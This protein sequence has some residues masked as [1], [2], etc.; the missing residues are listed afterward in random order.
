MDVP[1]NK[2]LPPALPQHTVPVAALGRA[3]GGLL[4]QRI[5]TINAPAGYGKSVVLAQL[6]QAAREQ[7]THTFWLSLDA[8]DIN[9]Q[10]LREWLSTLPSVA[11]KGKPLALFLDNCDHLFEGCAH[12]A[13]DELIQSSAPNVFFFLASRRALPLRLGKLRLAQQVGEA[14]MQELC[15]D[16]TAARSLLHEV[17]CR[18]L[19]DAQVQALHD[20]TEGWPAGLQLAALALR[21]GADPDTLVRELCQG[22][23][24]LTVYLDDVAL[25]ELPGELDAFLHCT[26][27]PSRFSLAWCREVLCVADPAS[28][29]KAIEQRGLPLI[30]LDR[31]GNWYRYLR[32]FGAT[33][34]KRMDT[35]APQEAKRLYRDSSIWFAASGASK[36]A[37]ECAFAAGDSQRA[38]T[39]L[40]H[41]ALDLAGRRGD[42]TRVMGWLSQLAPAMLERRPALRITRIAALLMTHRLAEADAE[43]AQ[44]EA[45][46]ALCLRPGRVPPRRVE[47]ILRATMLARCAWYGLTDQPARTVEA[48][49]RWMGMWGGVGAPYEVG[50]VLL[51]GGYNAC[52]MGDYVRAAADLAGA[53]R[54]MR[55]SDMPLGLAWTEVLTALVEFEAGSVAGADRMLLAA[56]ADIG[57]RFGTDCRGIALVAMMRASICYEQNRIEEAQA[58]LDSVGEFYDGR[59]FGEYTLSAYRTRARLL[60]L[61]GETCGAEL[62]RMQATSLAE[63]CGR[64]RFQLL[65]VSDCVQQLLRRNDL[66]A[67]LRL[68]RSSGLLAAAA[69]PAADGEVVLVAL[70]LQ[71]AGGDVAG[72]LANAGELREEVAETR[73]ESVMAARVEALLAVLHAR[74]GQRSKAL[75]AAESALRIGLACGACRALADEAGFGELLREISGRQLSAPQRRYLEQVMAA[76][77]LS[78]AAPAPQLT[79][80]VLSEKERRVL[81]LAEQG[82]R[83]RDMARELFVSDETIKWHLRNIYA[84]LEVNNRISALAKARALSLV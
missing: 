43:L 71:A 14:G 25:D 54:Q 82:L 20:V 76:L 15:M 61:Q 44:L 3:L 66:E 7:G 48:A 41:A 59:F 57:E 79:C 62:C 78:D 45:R 35:M 24:D 83:N 2:L 8:G 68:A 67:A 30:P 42:Y 26:A 52:L 49:R 70:R 46:P 69:A 31:N 53:R 36:E 17:G 75:A 34:R 11:P 47:G 33:L 5:F 51:L 32:P 6:H 1:R 27:L 18:S 37:I 80:P 21:R 9:G 12:L 50:S 40:E 56:Q 16:I 29:I 60:V 13:L 84:K 73:A 19:P 74:A 22:D 23:R 63:R 39:L 55:Q 10:R 38:A 65:L 77:P 4:Q 28:M 58:L 72:T 81:R 64:Q